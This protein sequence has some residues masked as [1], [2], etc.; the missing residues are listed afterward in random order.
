[1]DPNEKWLK[2]FNLL[3]SELLH[4]ARGPSYLSGIIKLSYLSMNGSN[5]QNKLN[6]INL[7]S[8]ETQWIL[9]TPVEFSIM[10]LHFEVIKRGNPHT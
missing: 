5:C 4:C 9:I 1:M 3:C 6:I 10:H 7:K 2:K 8:Q